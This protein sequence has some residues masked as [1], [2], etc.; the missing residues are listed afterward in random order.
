MKF[1]DPT[2]VKIEKTEKKVEKESQKE[3]GWIHD[4]AKKKKP[5]RKK[6]LK[7]RKI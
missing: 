5:S 3:S 7:K 1:N 2:E 6:V 4:P